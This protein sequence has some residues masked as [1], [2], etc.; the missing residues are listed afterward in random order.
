M[1]GA[2]SSLERSKVMLAEVGVLRA[3]KSSFD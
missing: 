1:N 2:L 3:I